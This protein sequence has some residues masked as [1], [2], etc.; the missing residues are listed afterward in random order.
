VGDVV[1]FLALWSLGWLLLWRV[2]TLAPAP[3][4][5]P[6]VTVVVPA[7]DEE[8]NLPVLLDALRPQLTTGDEV[9]VVDDGSTDGTASVARHHGATVL[10]APPLPPGWQGKSW[11]CHTGAAAAASPVLVFLDADVRLEPGGL[12]AVV[13]DA[14]A[15]DGL[16]SVQPWHEVPRPHERLA[17]L[18]N[19]VGL[20]AT[21][22]C[23][24]LGDRFP[25]RG[26]FGPCLATSAATY[27]RVGG[28]AAV[29]PEPLDDVALAGAYRGAGEPVRVRGGRG[30]VA[31]RMYP[32]GLGQLVEGFTKN[33]ALGA[34][35]VGPWGAGGAA[36]W[37]AAT[38]APLVL[39]ASR[40][41]L[42]VAAYL[43]VAGQL[44]VHLRRLG[45][46]G[47]ATAL[48]YALPL[49]AFLA[50][51]TRSALLVVLRGR[52]RWKGRDV[53]VGPGAGL[54][55]PRRRRRGA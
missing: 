37:V 53:T 21:G 55:P 31:F 50:V 36:A 39:A 29:A 44:H 41:A 19:V 12:D 30:T 2:P 42:G 14:V 10:T 23:T 4:P 24:P 3:G 15:A 33:I 7:R 49:V 16:T 27:R 48:L 11:A 18:F 47:A 38:V 28:H 43:A 13:A 45:T 25:V 6:P 9:I 5:R 8:T 34:R 20:M 22:A 51:F 32:R 17:A 1:A 46:F 40:P 26:A 35:S 54:R 52:V